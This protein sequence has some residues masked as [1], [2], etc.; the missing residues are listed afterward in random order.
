M[1]PPE[2]RF[3]DACAISADGGAVA[4]GGQEYYYESGIV[5]VYAR[6]STSGEWK[7][8]GADL[9][10]DASEDRFGFS[11]DL[12]E[13]GKTLIVG[14]HQVAKYFTDRR[15]YAK[16]Y[17]WDGDDEWR[18]KGEKLSGASER[19]YFG[20]S[21]SI[22]GDGSMVAIGSFGGCY[23][24]VYRWRDP[25]WSLH[26]KVIGEQGTLFGNAIKLSANGNIIAVGAPDELSDRG[27]IHV[28]AWDDSRYLPRGEVIRGFEFGDKVG[29]SVD[30]SGDGT[31]VA[32]GVD[33]ALA[34]VSVWEL[35][36]GVWIEKGNGF[37]AADNSCVSVSDHGNVLAVGQPSDDTSRANAGKVTVYYSEH[38]L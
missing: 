22:V 3:G 26:G 24:E 19:D 16:I 10:G 36:G 32:V 6:D 14:A 11:L 37:V 35:D 2:S 33:R 28:Y 29:Y 27:A 12:S 38:F 20:S 31:V 15:G 23:V 18:E 4:V 8:R 21:V 17:Q 5:R 7:Q 13:D 1:G 34:N 30:L 25:L 9:V